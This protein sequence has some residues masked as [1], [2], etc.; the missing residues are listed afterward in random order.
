MTV[1]DLICLRLLTE[2]NCLISLWNNNTQSL[3]SALYHDVFISMVSTTMSMEWLKLP[4]DSL[5]HIKYDD[6]YSTMTYLRTT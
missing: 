4:V 1:L 6:S 2:T 5:G 3:T